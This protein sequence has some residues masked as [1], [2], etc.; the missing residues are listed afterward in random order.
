MH[1]KLPQAVLLK[2]LSS[3]ELQDIMNQEKLSKLGNQVRIGGKVSH[4]IS[5]DRRN[6][7][8]TALRGV[9]QYSGSGAF[10]VLFATPLPLDKV[11]C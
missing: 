2:M 11:F 4:F 5:I 1:F 10:T 6:A 9:I 3:F 8:A 7:C